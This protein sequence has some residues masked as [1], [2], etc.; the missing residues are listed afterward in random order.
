[1]KTKN[2]FEK[3]FTLIEIIVVMAIFSII[4][5]AGLLVN[6][7]FLKN[8]ILKAEQS[9]IISALSKARSNS[10]NNI[11]QNAHGFCY[12]PPNYIIFRDT[13]STRCVAGVSTNQLI[14]ANV[15]IANNP[16]SSFPDTIIF[17]QLS[18]TT[19]P[20]SIHITDGVK[21]FDITINYEGTIIW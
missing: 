4:I 19:T 6:I 10:I 5:G 1:M 15:N 8:D 14:P 20:K 12:I 21:S 16:G 13:P 3:G 7:N 11:F 2:K 9:T 18:G 17:S